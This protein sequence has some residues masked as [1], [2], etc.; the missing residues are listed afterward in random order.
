MAYEIR[1]YILC[2]GWVNSWTVHYPDGSSAP[3]IFASYEEAEAELT[4]FLAEIDAE[5][6]S[7]ERAEDEGF[8]RG[9]FA[10]VRAGSP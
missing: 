1:Q 6:A 8:D 4:A 7:G 5:I 10:I 9:E 2:Q 3:E